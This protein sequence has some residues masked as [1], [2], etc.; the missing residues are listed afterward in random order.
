MGAATYDGDGQA[1]KLPQTATNRRLG[2]VTWAFI[3]NL[4][5][6]QQPWQGGQDWGPAGT[7]DVSDMCH[8]QLLSEGEPLLYGLGLVH[9]GGSHSA[10]ARQWGLHCCR[11]VL[12]NLG[13]AWERFGW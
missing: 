7:G 6:K 9:E 4:K 11:A 10:N 5:Q 2:V 1:E 8:A 12:G 13:D 3:L